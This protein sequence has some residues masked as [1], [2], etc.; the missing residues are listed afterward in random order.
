VRRAAGEEAKAET[1]QVQWVRIGG[2]NE[3]ISVPPNTRVRYGAGEMWVY[4]TMSGV[5]SA[6]NATFGDPIV[7]TAKAVFAQVA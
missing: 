7:G 3:S 2:E 4:R 5:F 6:S 1:T